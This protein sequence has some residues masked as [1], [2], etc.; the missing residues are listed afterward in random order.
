MSPSIWW[1]DCAIYQILDRV[2]Q[3]LPLKIWLDTGTNEPGWERARELCERLVEKG[4]RLGYDLEYLEV[5][6][7]EHN[8]AAWASRFEAVLRYLFPPL[9]PGAKQ[10]PPKPRLLTTR[11]R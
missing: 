3:K 9:P 4:W 8:E 1:D 2:E 6:G 11:I 7:G 5:K 10:P